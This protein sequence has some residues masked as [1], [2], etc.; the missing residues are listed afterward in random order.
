M[1]SS[2]ID[3][4]NLK[5]ESFGVF[6][7]YIIDDNVTDLNYYDGDLWIDDL[8][9]GRYRAKNIDIS[10]EFINQFSTRIANVVSR[11]FNDTDNVLEAETET[12]RVSILHNSVTARNQAISI[13]KTPAVR[14]LSLE[15]MMST[16]YCTKDIIYLLIEMAKAHMNIVFCGLPG[17]GKTELLKFLTQYIPK[18]EKVMTVE[19]NLEIHYRTIN[20]DS[21]CVEVKVDSKRFTYTDALKAVLRQNALWI[22]LSEARSSE[23]KYL[24]EAWSSGLNGFTTLHTDD[25]RKIPDRMQNMLHDN[26]DASRMANDIYSFVNVGVLIRKKLD[27]RTRNIKRYIDQVCFFDRVNG[28]NICEMAVVEGKMIKDYVMPENVE[29]KLKSFK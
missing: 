27:P 29:F 13:R 26:L 14:R 19:D 15:N 4:W 6:L 12:L 22:I 5:P 28:E 1:G 24:L 2:D 7:P 18:D 3:F 11:N 9:K 23:V 20:P 16:G 17:S 25:V 8:F 10:Q 21:N